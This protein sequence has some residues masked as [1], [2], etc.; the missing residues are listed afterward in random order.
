[1]C[2]RYALPEQL[3]AEREFV[4][5]QA[6]WK[7]T[8]RLNV[9]APQYVPAIRVHDG[10]SEG[11]MMRWG[12]IPSWAEGKVT[13]EVARCI[14]ADQ[15][16]RSNQHREP[17]LASQRCIL[18]VAGFYAWQL[19]RARYRQPYFVQ[20]LD[21]SVF[22]VAGIWD[23]S[24]TED[25]DVVESCSIVQVPANDLMRQIA[26]TEHDMLAILQ[27]KHYATWL[28]GTPG[29][30]KSALQPYRSE[31]M[32]AYAVSPRVNSTA[33]DDLALIRP[34]SWN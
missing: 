21:R 31:A 10:Q 16:E 18:P 26:N 3:A 29:E 19:T 5:T 30:A 7:F 14:E 22:G 33:A 1:M 6:W 9:A 34:V 4:P 2:E 23:R 11:V 25:D 28:H 24:V 8:R 27:R 32:Q 13:G 20:L 15:I 12:L 17:W